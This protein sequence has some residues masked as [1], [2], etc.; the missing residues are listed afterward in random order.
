MGPRRTF[1]FAS[2]GVWHEYHSRLS[3]ITREWSVRTVDPEDDVDDL[4]RVAAVMRE[5]ERQQLREDV[6]ALVRRGLAG[7]YPIP[8]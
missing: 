2:E 5:V 8:V 3:Q 6:V 7:P 1:V 4:L